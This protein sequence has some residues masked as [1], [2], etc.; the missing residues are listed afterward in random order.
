MSGSYC[1]ITNWNVIITSAYNF[2]WQ[3]VVFFVPVQIRVLECYL[4][5]FSPT[6]GEGGGGGLH[7]LHWLNYFC[8]GRTFM[9]YFQSKSCSNKI[10]IIVSLNTRA[11]ET[12]VGGG[13]CPFAMIEIVLSFLK[14]DT[15]FW[16]CCST[17]SILACWTLEICTTYCILVLLK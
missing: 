15:T 4:T 13:T 16:F 12:L 9:N 10:N 11:D 14:I 1:P 17:K 7:T 5:K 3:I 8:P 2:I 6:F